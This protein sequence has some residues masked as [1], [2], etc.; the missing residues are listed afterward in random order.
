MKS[1]FLILIILIFVQSFDRVTVKRSLKSK[2]VYVKSKSNVQKSKSEIMSKFGR[3][4]FSLS[5]IR[6]K[7]K[8][9]KKE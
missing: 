2:N 7:K 8:N 4:K 5:K 9:T 3:D 1:I 6:N